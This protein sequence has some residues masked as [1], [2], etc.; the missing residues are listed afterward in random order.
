MLFITA[1]YLVMFRLGGFFFGFFFFG[2]VNPVVPACS[3]ALPPINVCHPYVLC[4]HPINRLLILARRSVY[5]FIVESCH[6][7]R[8]LYVLCLLRF[9]SWTMPFSCLYFAESC[10]KYLAV[11]IML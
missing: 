7:Y 2:P 10:C 1:L 9:L 11:N 3:L 6:R 5:P 8:D 4:Y